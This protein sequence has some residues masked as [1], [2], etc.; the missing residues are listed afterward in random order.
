M[1]DRAFEIA[2]NRNYDGYQRTLASIVYKFFDKKRKKRGS[3]ISVNEQLAEEIHKP[4]NK[5]YKR[6][7]VYARFKDNIWFSWNWIIVFKE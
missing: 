6:R 5:K 2:R 7:K 3:R 4:V 1:K